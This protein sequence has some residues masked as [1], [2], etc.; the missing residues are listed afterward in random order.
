MDE[1]F[2]AGF[3]SYTFSILFANF[4]EFAI[5]EVSKILNVSTELRKLDRMFLKLQGMV[6]RMEC[7]RAYLW[8]STH[9]K[10]SIAWV[11]E[12]NGLI[13]HISDILEDISLN[14]GLREGEKLVNGNLLIDKFL[15]LIPRKISGIVEDLENLIK[16]MGTDFLV[17]LVKQVP[18]VVARKQCCGFAGLSNPTHTI[19]RESQIEKVVEILTQND[20]PLCI[21]GMAG[22]GKTVFTLCLCENKEVKKAFPLLLWVSV[23]A[24]FELVRILRAAIESV[25]KE[26]CYLTDLNVLRS[27]LQELLLSGD[28]FLVVLDDLCVEDLEDWNLLYAAFKVESKSSR[29]VFTT[30]NSKVASFIGAKMFCLQ[31]LSD[32]DC[33]KIIKQRPFI[34][35]K[36]HN[37]EVIGLEIAKK[38]KGVPLVAKTIGDILHCLPVN[39]WDS[40]VKGNLWDLP[41]IE[42]HVF[43]IF[44]LS[45]CCL[46][47]HIKKC[48]SYC[49]LFP[50]EYVY[51]MK[52][53]VLLWMAEGLIHPIDGRRIEDIGREYFEE[54][55]WGSLFNSGNEYFHDF[56]GSYTMHEFNHHVAA[57][58]SSSIC[59]RIKDNQSSYSL[60]RVRHLSICHG[61]TQSNGLHSFSKCHNLRTFTL[62]CATNIGPN[63][64]TLFKNFKV[65]RVLNLKCGGITEIPEIVG[66]LK[67]LRYLDLSSNNINTLPSS[68]CELSLL[69][70]LILENC[71]SLM[72]LPDKFSRLTNLRHLFFDVKHQIHQ[73]P[74]NF[75]FLK[76]LQTLNAFVVEA[77]NGHTIE[78]LED[79]NSL[80][81]SFSLIGLENILNGQSAATANLNEKQGIIELELQWRSHHERNIEYEILTGLQPHKNLERLLISDYR[82]TTFPSWLWYGPHYMLRSI[83]LRNCE[84]CKG[85]PP[86]GKLQ[87]LESLTIEN[88]TLLVSAFTSLVDL[89]V[90]PSLKSL[91]FSTMPQLIG[92]GSGE[93][94]MPQ[95]TDLKFYTCPKLKFLPE[96]SR[97]SSL[98]CLEIEK[99]EGLD[100]LPSSS[101]SMESFIIRDSPALSDSCQ[102]GGKNWSTL[103]TIPFVQI[104]QLVMPTTPQQI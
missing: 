11:E 24:E 103:K 79:L 88:M 41:Q 98:K 99:C 68:L 67:H 37:L 58:V 57:S 42:N 4:T 32:E 31:P 27:T 61:N 86:L 46:P 29:L 20:V 55:V 7:S 100:W 85:L 64:P 87:F 14:L 43:P 13:Y 23:S 56:D 34:N 28:N 9:Y 2:R 19:G 3:A 1:D 47:Q 39:E 83:Y 73:M 52:D 45:Y 75:R 76:E 80:T 40:L 16:E 97:L 33:W 91:V 69:Q 72:C 93:Y 25:S 15:L 62:L 5:D 22:I 102:V 10:S 12:A 90:F 78:E 53:I 51:K 104:D 17:D 44:L 6:Y 59:Q 65:I 70:V 94:D 49:C 36:M 84:C 18:K 95:L 81:G 54:L 38:C 92:W 82:G 8:D 89:G 50:P 63:V 21:T 66:N 74:V 26:S 71:T 96:L 35:N 30:R 77:E 101:A 60:D 48:F